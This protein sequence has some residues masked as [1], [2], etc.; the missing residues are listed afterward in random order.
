MYARAFYK[1]GCGNYEKDGKLMNDALGLPEED[2]DE[3]TRNAV[4]MA[5]TGEAAY[6]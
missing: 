4:K 3:C 1:D 5:Q 6:H 2:L